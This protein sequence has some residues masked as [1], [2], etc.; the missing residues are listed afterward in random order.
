MA[1]FLPVC[2]ILWTHDLQYAEVLRDWQQP[3]CHACHDHFVDLN[4]K[5]KYNLG[6]GCIYSHIRGN[7]LCLSQLITLFV[8]MNCDQPVTI[9]GVRS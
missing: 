6:L 7:D 5:S 9:T 2:A 1:T 4:K 8:A 3:H